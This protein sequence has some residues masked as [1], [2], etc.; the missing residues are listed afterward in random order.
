MLK[1]FRGWGDGSEDQFLV[2]STWVCSSQLPVTPALGDLCAAN[3]CT[4]IKYKLKNNRLKRISPIVL[5]G[6]YAQTPHTPYSIRI[7]TC[8]RNLKF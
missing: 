5:I 2:L 4:C 1:N 6:L 7:H 3:K 8:R